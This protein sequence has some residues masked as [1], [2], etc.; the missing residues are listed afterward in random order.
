LTN[1]PASSFSGATASKESQSNNVQG[2]SQQGGLS[3]GTST[4]SDKNGASTK[5]IV[6]TSNNATGSS[7]T[8]VTKLQ[9]SSVTQIGS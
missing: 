4:T 1:G 6:S 3:L 2:V 8:L 5:S 7:N 9:S